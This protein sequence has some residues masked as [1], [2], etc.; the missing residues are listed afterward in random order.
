MRKVNTCRY[1]DLLCFLN[2]N[3][4]RITLIQWFT[5]EPVCQVTDYIMPPFPVFQPTT[6]CILQCSTY[7]T[8]GP[9]ACPTHKLTARGKSRILEGGVGGDLARRAPA[10]PALYR[11]CRWRGE[12]TPSRPPP[13]QIRAR[14]PL[15][16][17][18]K[19]PAVFWFI[20]DKKVYIY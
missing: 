2:T 6:G 1:K 14:P 9:P 10:V 7:N 19:L 15:S 8:G 11:S 17:F 13:R 20:S 5:F 18:T 16:L 3:R 4:R 12:G